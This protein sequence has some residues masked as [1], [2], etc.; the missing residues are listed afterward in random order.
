[1][2]KRILDDSF[3]FFLQ[4]TAEQR[5]LSANEMSA[6]YSLSDKEHGDAG[7]PDLVQVDLADVARTRERLGGTFVVD[8]QHETGEIALLNFVS[9]STTKALRNAELL[10]WKTNSITFSAEETN[11]ELS[12]VTNIL[13]IKQDLPL[14]RATLKASHAYSESSN[15]EDILFSYWQQANAGF[16]NRG[17]LS[18][19]DPKT[20]ATIAQ[21]M[22][23]AAI[24]GRV[25]AA[26]ILSQERTVNGSLDLETNLGISDMFTGT[27]KF[28]GAL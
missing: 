28:G 25:R 27:L 10:P 13:S 20:L 17:D 2:E 4:L 22:A 12:T 9:R 3:G 11:N 24:L 16:A 7:V 21:P 26:T 5:N 1:V 8:Y 15:P 6:T 18:K 14:F 23:S 19:V